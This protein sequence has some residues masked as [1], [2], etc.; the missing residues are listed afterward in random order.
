MTETTADEIERLRREATPDAANQLRDIVESNAEKSLVKAAKRALYLLAQQ[1]IVPE[2]AE[3]SR[4]EPSAPA[5]SNAAPFRAYAS[6]GD[7]A[8]Y[9]MLVFVEPDKDGGSPRLTKMV[10]NPD[11]GIFNFGGGRVT[12]ADAAHRIEQLES[13]LDE[14]VAFAEI[15]PE[16]AVL[17]L[18]TAQDLHGRIRGML[19][20]GCHGWAQS[21]GI[22]KQSGA[23]GLT[24]PDVDAA[25]TLE[26]ADAVQLFALPWFENWLLDESAGDRMFLRWYQNGILED[27]QDPTEAHAVL[28]QLVQEDIGDLVPPELREEYARR[29]EHTAAIL[30]RRDRQDAARLAL[31]H[32]RT[33]T[34]ET[35]SANIPFLALLGVRSTLTRVS[36]LREE[37][38]QRQQNSK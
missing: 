30:W 23:F 8:G 32:A 17:L 6:G 36:E 25:P 34:G 11:E 28:R 10:V 20:Q 24:L 38:V 13:K 16:E 5:L 1:G 35:P 3:I 21:L 2:R 18:G 4:V 29:L 15:T 26:E 7:G 14:G 37:F 27:T 12:R 22:G 33:L 9:V 19:P 31:A